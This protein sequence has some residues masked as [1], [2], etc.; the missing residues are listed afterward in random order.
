MRGS[1]ILKIH[2]FV[3]LA[4]KAL[5]KR[6]QSDVGLSFSQCMILVHVAHNPHVSQQHVACERDITP[7]A[8]SRHIEALVSSGLIS[9]FDKVHNKREHVLEITILGKGVVETAE[10]ILNEEINIL[11]KELSKDEASR[12]ESVFD[13]L[14]SHF[15]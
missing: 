11:M 8:V 13:R 10:D 3:F 2:K 9:R 6:L 14:L 12:I 5:D 1:P 7:A 15:S 4:E